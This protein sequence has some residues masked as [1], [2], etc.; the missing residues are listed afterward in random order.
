MNKELI[1]SLADKAVEKVQNRPNGTCDMSKYNV[2][3]ARLIVDECIN[4]IDREVVSDN[5][6]DLMVM[7]ERHFGI[8]YPPNEHIISFHIS[9]DY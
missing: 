4:L 5:S 8:T 1:E 6:E 9:R 2:E 3:F 7:I